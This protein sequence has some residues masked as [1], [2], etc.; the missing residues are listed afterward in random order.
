[1]PGSAIVTQLFSS[2]MRVYRTFPPVAPYT[3]FSTLLTPD[4]PRQPVL[5]SDLTC[6]LCGLATGRHSFLGNRPSS[7]DPL[8][9][10]AIRAN[11][12]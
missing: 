7:N 1:M 9:V 12:T 5:A 4:P 6:C 3:M 11:I 2:L 10:D 8:S